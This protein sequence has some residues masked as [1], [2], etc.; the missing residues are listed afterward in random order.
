M[1]VAREAVHHRP[2]SSLAYAFDEETVHVRLRT[3]RGD[4]DACELLHGDKYDWPASAQRTPMTVVH[5]DRHVD[6]WQVAVRPENR[7]L[8]YAFRLAD[9]DEAVWYTERGF[10]SATE[11]PL[12]TAGAERPLDYF[13]YPFLNPADVVDP[14]DWVVEAVFYQ[15]F[16]ERFANGDPDTDP[17]EAD[18]WDGTPELDNYYGGDLQGI[19]DHLDYLD[20]LGVTALYLTPIFEAD[21]NHKYNT[22]DYKRIDS[23]FGD[24]ET[25]RRLVDDAHDRGMRVVLDAVFNHSGRQFAPFQD[26]VEKGADSAYAD[27]FH[28]HE[29]P[30]RFEPRPSYDAWGFES[31]MPKLNTENPEVRAYLLDVATYWIEAVD[32][33]GWRLDVANEVD[34]RF[35]RA[36]RR[37]VKALKPDA[38]ILGEIW[39]D[40]RPWLRGDQFDAV[41]NYPVTNALLE[42]VCEE[43]IDATEFADRVG[44][45]LFRYPDQVND[46][47]FNLVGSHDTPR[48]RHRCRD[49]LRRVRLA[50]LL[51]LTFRG[52]PCIYY[53]DEVG[54]T[55]GDDPDCRRP[56][57]WDESEQDRDLHRFF[58]DLVD[59]RTSHAALQRGSLRFVREQCSDERLVYR[60]STGDAA[61][62]VWVAINR[63]TEPAGIDLPSDPGQDVDLLFRTTSDP[64]Q[65]DEDGTLELPPMAGAVW[66]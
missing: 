45:L 53:G 37:E 43:S 34:H 2:K 55:G 18:A 48:I 3:K 52:V 4:L 49:D 51:L 13:E 22:T 10:E 30:L 9:G 16:P 20:D 44:R 26:V 19:I 7:R 41:M 57:V 38:Y 28:V 11:K 47:L 62:A 23:Q 1:T 25:L 56:M 42:F 50:A 29:F 63:G 32:I 33:D 31:Y 35:W 24:E 12:P 54:M 8:C 61:D 14:P 6:Y 36:L 17:A 40:A 21:S 46:V 65:R 39:H 59:L 66:R 58:A 60:R 64:L 27:W 15:L 5:R